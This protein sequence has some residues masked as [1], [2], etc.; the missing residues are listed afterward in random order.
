MRAYWTLVRREL[1]AYFFSWIGYAVNAAALLLMGV[2]FSLL[3]NNL[4]GKG[5]EIPITQIFCQSWFFWI[6]LLVTAPMITMRSF[7]LEKFSGTFETLMTA[8]VSDVQVV[9]AKFTGAMISYLVLW[10]PLLGCLF[11]ARHFSNDPTILDAGSAAGTGLGILLLGFLYISM[12]C[13]AS[14]VTRHQI[15][16][17]M[18]GLALGISLFLPSFVSTESAAPAAW[19]TGLFRYVDLGDHMHEFT[20]GVVDSRP[21]TLYLSLTVFFLFLT[22]KVVESRRWK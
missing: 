22:W 5:T 11:V 20:R 19:L 4:N 16:A 18:F 7:A 13:F 12:G 6:I 14:A 17:A 15:I 1:E 2:S 9:L 8:P 10:L 3:F 21:V